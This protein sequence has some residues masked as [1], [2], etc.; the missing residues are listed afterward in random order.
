VH[1]LVVV[2]AA[3]VAASSCSPI[4]AQCSAWAN[5]E[6]P[7][8]Y[9]NVEQGVSE[10]ACV[11]DADFA[12][13]FE[14]CDVEYDAAVSCETEHPNCCNDVECDNGA[15]ACSTERTAWS[16]CVSRLRDKCEQAAG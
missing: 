8:A 6:C 1:K 14:N 5:A 10:E 12:C 9:P 3:I 16:D 7:D 2:V 11:S 15:A 4:A 13:G